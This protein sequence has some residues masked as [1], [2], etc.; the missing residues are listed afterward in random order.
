MV[1]Q[2]TYAYSFSVLKS[3]VLFNFAALVKTSRMW[4]SRINNR[5]SLILKI[6]N[7]SRF[8]IVSVSVTLSFGVYPFYVNKMYFAKRFFVIVVV[9]VIGRMNII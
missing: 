5:D 6:R 4:L 7:A 9:V 3:F 8:P 2:S 1:F